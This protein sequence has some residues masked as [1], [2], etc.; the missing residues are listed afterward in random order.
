MKKQVA[1]LVF[2]TALAVCGVSARASSFY[3]LEGSDNRLLEEAEVR[4]WSCEAMPYLYDE[5]FARH[6]FHFEPGGRFDNYFRC[7]AWYAESEELET[8]QEV[9]DTLREIEWKNVQL[10]K[11]VRRSMEESGDLNPE[12]KKIPD[13]TTLTELPGVFSSFARKAFAPGQS[14]KVLTGPG[15]AYMAGLTGGSAPCVSTNDAIWVGGW[16]NDWLLILYETNSGNVRVGYVSRNSF[17]DEIKAPDLS[18]EHSA[19]S[20]K[21]DCTLTDDPVANGKHFLKL[22]EGTEVK[23]LS[24]YINESAW[25]YVEVEQDGIKARGFLPAECVTI[26]AESEEAS[27]TMG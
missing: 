22:T 9:Y 13:V 2:A 26:P 4:E 5:I 11:E 6:G 27:Q 16:E 3:L 15:E 25:A 19:A 24:T 14:M 12:G 17:K 1:S 10:I 7:Q 21:S 23:Y 18:Y 20:I 8:N